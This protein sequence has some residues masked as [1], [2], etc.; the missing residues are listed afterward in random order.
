MSES[1]VRV[2]LRYVIV[3]YH[4]T[5]WL[6]EYDVTAAASTAAVHLQYKKYHNIIKL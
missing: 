6:S 3:L 4:D 5:K 1:I 2:A